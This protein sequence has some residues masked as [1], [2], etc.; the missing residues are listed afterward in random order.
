MKRIEFD[1]A[2]IESA[3]TALEQSVGELLPIRTGCQ[4]RRAVR[5]LNEL[6][7]VVGA[8]ERHPLAGLLDVLGELVSAYEAREVAM[9][10]STPREVLRLLMQ[11]NGLTQAE[12]GAELGGQ[13]V[14]STI[15][16]G[17][18][19]INAR[20]ASALATRFGISPAAFI[21]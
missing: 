1:S 11:T 18:R 12:L 20:Q 16:N 21:G 14:V 15:L 8:D 2:S 17:K 3:W 5:L 6:L 9:P 7:D 13:P 4:Y 19:A 10:A